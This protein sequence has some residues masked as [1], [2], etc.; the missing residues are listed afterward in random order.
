MFNPKLK[1]KALKEIREFCS[2]GANTSDDVILNKKISE[3]NLDT[4][5]NLPGTNLYRVFAQ[6]LL[7]CVSVNIAGFDGDFLK[8]RKDKT[9][10]YVIDYLDSVEHAI[11]SA[12]KEQGGKNAN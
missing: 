4:N 3:L 11:I 5:P 1:E 2:F 6:K 10:D 8:A 12:L 7:S 9:V